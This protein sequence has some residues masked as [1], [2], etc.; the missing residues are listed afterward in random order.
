MIVLKVKRE[1][2]TEE[3]PRSALDI[4]NA[5]HR[6]LKEQPEHYMYAN[7]AEVDAYIKEERESWDC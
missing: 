6:L 7:A 5:H 1:E 3:K 2:I 4:L